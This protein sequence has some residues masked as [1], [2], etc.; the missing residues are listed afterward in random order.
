M[1]LYRLLRLSIYLLATSGAV[2]VWDVDNDLTPILAV[3]GAAA[4]AFVTVDAGRLRPARPAVAAAFSLALLVHFLRSAILTP[5]AEDSPAGVGQLMHFLLALQVLLFFSSFRGSLVFV[6]CGANLFIVVASGFLEA[7]PSLLIRLAFV[8]ATA[9]WLLFVHCLWLEQVRFENRQPAEKLA[10]QEAAQPQRQFSE[11][12]LWQGLGLTGSVAASCLAFGFLLFFA[13]PR[14]ALESLGKMLP[15]SLRG[16]EDAGGPLRPRPYQGQA[17]IRVTGPSETVDLDELAPIF[18]DSSPALRVGFDRPAGELAGRGGVLYLRDRVLHTYRRNRWLTPAPMREL[19]APERESW[20]ELPE[21]DPN[22][23][24]PRG[25]VELVRQ[26]VRLLGMAGRTFLTLAPVRE[27]RQPRVAADS[28]GALYAPGSTLLTPSA[29]YEAL[30]HRPIYPEELPQGIRSEAPAPRYLHWK[31]SLSRPENAQ[32]LEALQA[33]IL[34]GVKEDLAKALRLRDWLRES[35]HCRYTLRATPA[36]GGEDRLAEFLLAAEPGRRRGSCGHFATAF[37]LLAR[38]AGLPA[39]LATGFAHTLGAEE[40]PRLGVTFANSEAHAWGEVYFAGCG[41]VAFDPTPASGDPEHRVGPA[42]PAGPHRPRPP[43][44][45]DTDAFASARP[46]W[47]SRLW[48]YFLSY[49]GR[50]QDRLYHSLGD[51][52]KALARRTWMATFGAGDWGQAGPVLGWVIAALLAGAFAVA[53][54]QR[55]TR[56]RTA[57]GLPPSQ[58]AA[59]IFYNEL[60]QALSRR[61]FVRRRTQTPREFARAVVVR[62]GKALEPVLTLTEVFERVRYG[63]DRM[64]AGEEEAVRQALRAV[65]EHLLAPVSGGTAARHS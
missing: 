51:S 16:E 41:W 34:R 23:L 52:V 12:A 47:V 61:G 60:L 48:G 49:D 22:F 58:R 7:G 24:A 55:Q 3:L 36:E 26:Q 9:T 14:G 38:A 31:G 43:L 29:S 30:S 45:P 21:D 57:A 54:R 63:G 59:V 15:P 62:G 10:E 4:L 25:P 5:G 2:A 27:I 64:S 1:E 46:G 50:A 32:A 19:A 44:G 37:V 13:W 8:L 53:V 33:F 35:G 11:Q 18:V 42:P 17:P 6:F 28:E 40:A 65:Q 39:R 20:I 56:R